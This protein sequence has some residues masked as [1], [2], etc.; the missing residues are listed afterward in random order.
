MTNPGIMAEDTSVTAD[1]VTVP[2]PRKPRL[3]PWVTLVDLGDNR[4]QLRGAEYSFTLQH[5]VFIE[6]FQSVQTLLDGQHTVEEIISSCDP[7]YL[8]TTITFLLKMLRSNGIL[9]EGVISPP[10]SLTPENLKENE[11]QVQFFSHFVLDP[12]GTLDL[13]Y[14]ARVALIGSDAL[15]SRV[16]QGLVGMG[17]G[18]LVRIE[19]LSKKT[20]YDSSQLH[21]EVSDQLEGMDFLIV[22]QDTTDYRFFQTLNAVCL[23]TQTRWMHVSIS[24]TKGLMG[25][26]IIPHQ[27]ACYVCYDTR[28]A[29][30]TS[31]LQGYRAYQSQTGPPKT[32]GFLNPLWSTLAEQVT[33]EVARIISGFAP[34][35]TIGRLYEFEATTPLVE[36]HDVLRL[37][38]CPACNLK[39][40]KTEPWDLLLLDQ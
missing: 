7:K 30:N 10:P 9:Q 36:G 32:E 39:E 12:V 16:Q 15:T 37:P 4:M 5:P 21:K 27:T 38:R 28:M 14:N 24:G 17:F 34:P 1:Y 18:S 20:A 26:T 23:E 33:L 25:P 31:E 35:K 3:A 6:T 2:L 40:P 22:C 13:L 11:S 29:S 8:P 19:G